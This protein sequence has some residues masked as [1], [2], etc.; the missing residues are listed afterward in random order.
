[1]VLEPETKKILCH[2]VRIK[3]L[4]IGK[5]LIKSIINATKN[6][7]E[8][9]KEI[10]NKET[11]KVIPKHQLNVLRKTTKYIRD[12]GDCSEVHVN[13]IIPD[14]ILLEDPYQSIFNGIPEVHS[15]LEGSNICVHCGAKRFKHEFATFCCMS[16]KTKFAS[17]QIP[18]ELYH[19][20][21]SEEES[22]K[23]FR[24]NMCAYNTNFCFTSMGVELDDDLNNM[25]SGVYTFLVNGAIYHK[26]DQLVPR[27]GS[28]RYLQLYFYDSETDFTHRL[29]WPNI[30]RKIIQVLVGVLSTNPYITTFRSLRE[31][32]PLDN[33]RV[34]L[35][36]SVELDQRVFN[37]PTTSEVV[38]IWVKG[39]DNITT[40]KR[41]IVVYGRSDCSTQIQPY[42]GC[43]DPLSYPLFFPN[44]ESGWDG[45]IA[46]DG[47]SI[48]EVVGNG[49][50]IVDDLEGANSK[51]GRNTVTMYEYYCYKFQIRSSK[52]LILL[53]RRLLQQFVVDIYIKIETS[54][55]IFCKLNQKKIRY[56]IYQGIVDVLMP[57]KLNQVESVNG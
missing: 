20:F 32:G 54:P 2:I 21:I 40:Y 45:K 22:S 26:I 51:K 34:T 33:Y 5:I 35:N 17:S 18:D 30:D 52:N 8:C 6:K 36:A 13:Q 23:I 4:K 27:D 25:K 41:S 7:G 56:D 43:Y 47:V 46:R 24:D 1:M 10:T 31:L 44:G 14:D 39:N 12:V 50:N 55:L 48:N 38:G 15:I 42:E 11:M 49:E 29:Q 53:G 37:R 57:V 3:L 19:L 28:P 9:L 16:G